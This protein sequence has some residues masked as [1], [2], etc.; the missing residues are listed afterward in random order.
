MPEIVFVKKVTA[1]GAPCRKCVEVERRLRAGG[2]WHHI[3]RVVVAD[4]RD[5]ASEGWAL[6]RAHGV[7]RAPF[8]V[9]R[10]DDGREQV[11]TV[12]LKLVRELLHR[13]AAAA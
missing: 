10:H 1:D 13:P 7:D 8:F 5:S 3:T 9:V 11:Y 12:Y 2:H 4:E 6:A